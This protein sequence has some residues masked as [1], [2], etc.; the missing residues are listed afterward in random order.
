MDA[1][2]LPVQRLRRWLW[3]RR[4]PRRAARYPPRNP[5]GRPNGISVL[6]ISALAWTV[7]IGRK[8]VLLAIDLILA[9]A[10]P[11]RVRFGEATAWS[12]C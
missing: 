2:L 11:H 9:T 7:T 8:V 5:P 3:S 1:Y 10:R 4:V 6:D 12:V